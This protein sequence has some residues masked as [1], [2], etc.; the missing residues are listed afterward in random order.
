MYSYLQKKEIDV[1]ENHQWVKERFEDVRKELKDMQARL[2]LIMASPAD[3]NHC[4]QI[5]GKAEKFGLTCQFHVTPS[6]T[7][8][9]STVRLLSKWEFEAAS[10]PTVL[11]AVAAGNTGLGMM[12]SELTCLPVISY[13][14]LINNVDNYSPPLSSGPGFFVV[15]TSGGVACNAAHILSQHNMRVWSNL[16][17]HRLNKAVKNLASHNGE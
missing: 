1:K 7:S 2:I 11:V 3:R 15:H 8:I 13:P 9:K 16:R 10:T 4:I 6:Y 14:I 12:L 17:I 5:R